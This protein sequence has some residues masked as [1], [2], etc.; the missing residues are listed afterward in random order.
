MVVNINIF[1]RN[2]SKEALF[3]KVLQDYN[4]IHFV[5]TTRYKD[6]NWLQEN[7][8]FGEIYHLTYSYGGVDTA[9]I[10]K[11]YVEKM[12]EEGIFILVTR[13]GE[14][15]SF[16][17]MDFMNKIGEHIYN[18]YENYTDDDLEEVEEDLGE[19]RDLFG[20]STPQYSLPIPLPVGDKGG[21]SVSGKKRDMEESE[22]V[23]EASNYT[24]EF[25]VVTQYDLAIYQL[26]KPNTDRPYV[27]ITKQFE[28]YGHKRLFSSM[29]MFESW[30]FPK[31]LMF[32]QKVWENLGLSN[33]FDLD[34]LL[35][36]HVK[37]VEEGEP[38]PEVFRDTL[39]NV[40]TNYS[41]KNIRFV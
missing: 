5:D 37:A 12:K 20:M 21:C 32:L 26:T 33:E 15:E 31:D 10:K 38:E 3:I 36:E 28:K 2:Y 23:E 22:K 30:L 13:N 18:S 35:E 8:K 4:F 14:C 34:K 17:I 19:F 27:I 6:E 9:I 11:P 29:M 16:D 41:K 25:Q 40:K 39:E 24:F 7:T 1:Y